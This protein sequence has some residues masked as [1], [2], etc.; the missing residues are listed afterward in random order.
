MNKTAS[1]VPDVDIAPLGEVLAYENEDVVDKFLESWNLSREEAQDIFTEMK[2][3][4]WISADSIVRESRGE[5]MPILAISYPMTL[6]D[7][8]WHTFILFTKEYQHF[9]KQYFGFYINH[10]P[11]TKRQKDMT[12]AEIERDPEGFKAKFQ[13]EL[14][15]QYSYTYDQLGADTLMKWYSEWTD[16][17]TPEY[18]QSIRRPLDL[19][20]DH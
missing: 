5:Q 16:R 10:A 3:W 1:V 4:L 12:L 11:T 15:A 19:G 17:V 20:Y 2:K 6:L 14:A 8:M 7:E 18:L 9:C 13:E